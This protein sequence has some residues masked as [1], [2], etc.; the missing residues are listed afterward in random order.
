M[1]EHNVPANLL[2]IIKH[3]NMLNSTKKALNIC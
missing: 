3:Y 1:A 2:A